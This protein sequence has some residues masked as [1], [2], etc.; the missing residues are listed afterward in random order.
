M[1]VKNKK[2]TFLEAIFFRKKRDK[3][4]SNKYET[5]NNNKFM[6]SKGKG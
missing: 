1:E 5:K 3:T 4:H 6:K 2:N